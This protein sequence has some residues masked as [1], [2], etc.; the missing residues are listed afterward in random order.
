[1]MR[2]R[3]DSAMNKVFWPTMKV[4][5]MKVLISINRKVKQKGKNY[6]LIVE[7]VLLSWISYE[8]RRKKG[9][10]ETKEKITKNNAKL[11]W[12]RHMV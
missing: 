4:E 12:D 8:M 7:N 1:M 5:W 9:E 10:C 11:G 6:Y 3:K 2:E